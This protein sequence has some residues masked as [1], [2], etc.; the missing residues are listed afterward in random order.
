MSLRSLETSKTIEP[1]DVRQSIMTVPRLQGSRRFQPLAE[2]RLCSLEET[3]TILADVTSKKSAAAST[4]GLE[5]QNDLI[6]YKPSKMRP[7][8]QAHSVVA[9]SVHRSEFLTKAELEDRR[10]RKTHIEFSHYVITPDSY[11]SSQV[12]L[13]IAIPASAT[14]LI[15]ID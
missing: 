7:L 12:P 1:G 6:R 5:S 2:G 8:P 3:Y 14:P 9:I 4:R 13:T 10:Q 15:I 11:S